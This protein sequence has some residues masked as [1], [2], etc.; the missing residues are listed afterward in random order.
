MDNK[1]N[2]DLVLSGYAFQD[3]ETYNY[4]KKEMENIQIITAKVDLNDE[5]KLVK[6][7]NLLNKNE[8]PKSII[9]YT[10]LDELREMI[11]DINPDRL[12]DPI[13][14]TNKNLADSSEEFI[15]K[16]KLEKGKETSDL[17]NINKIKLRNSKIINLFLALTIIIMIIISIQA[18]RTVFKKFEESVIDKYSQ[19]QED[20]E[21]REKALKEK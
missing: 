2:I 16:R 17:L 5:V 18:D 4:A 20:L 21:A 6:L 3:E 12:V 10:F 19:W 14:I 13:R 7:Y 8:N 11:V 9:T 1:K 15:V